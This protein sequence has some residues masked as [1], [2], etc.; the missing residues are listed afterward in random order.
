MV[1]TFGF[2][3]RPALQSVLTDLVSREQIALLYTVIAVGDGIGSAA[4]SLILNRTLSVAI[5]W[6]NKL[7]LGLPFVVGAI[8]YSS[9]FAASCFAGYRALQTKQDVSDNSVDGQ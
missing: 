7:Y 8:F 1:F 9:G 3:T 5:G 2:S 6:D 4:G